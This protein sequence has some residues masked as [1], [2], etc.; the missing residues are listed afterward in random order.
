MAIKNTSSLGSLLCIVYQ[1]RICTAGSTSPIKTPRSK[2][3]QI[4]N[5]I[6]L[7]GSKVS[8][9]IPVT[10]VKLHVGLIWPTTIIFTSEHIIKSLYRDK[11]NRE[12]Q[13]KNYLL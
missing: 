7:R 13:N 2:P 5:Q 4:L 9:T 6:Y 1:Y 12:E 11:L 3:T 10:S 8:I